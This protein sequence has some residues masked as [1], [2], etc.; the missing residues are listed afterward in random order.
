[1]AT[2]TPLGFQLPDGNDPVRF[3]D[4]VMRANGLLTDALI[5]ELQT[6]LPTQFDGGAPGTV[7]ATDQILDGGTV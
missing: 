6:R 2:V 3:G 1:M 5:R 7:Y 4:D